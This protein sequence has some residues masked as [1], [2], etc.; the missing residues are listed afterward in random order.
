MRSFVAL[1]L[2]AGAAQLAEGLTRRVD[3]GRP[4]K[5]ENLHITLAFLDDQP[6][7]AL[8]A[9][10]EELSTIRLPAPLVKVREVGVFGG[11]KPRILYA[12]I[13]PEPRLLALRDAVRRAVRAAGIDLPHER[14]HPHITLARM[15]PTDLAA[16]AR[17]A[18]YLERY[19]PSTTEPER[20]I[21]FGLFGSHLHPDG[22]RYEPLAL[23]PFAA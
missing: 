6:D 4:T 3:F 15:T 10:G 11:D 5:P 16:H 22:V 20:A 1:T 13:E 19:G 17:L 12:D 2:P 21:A 18:C 8:T 23:F 14:Y 9:I 7:A